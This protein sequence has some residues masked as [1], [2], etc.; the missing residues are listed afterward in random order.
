[1]FLEVYEAVEA[2]RDM[3]KA[4]WV[5]FKSVKSSE[6]DRWP[7]QHF[8]KSRAAFT[9]TRSIVCKPLWHINETLSQCGADD[10]EW[11]LQLLNQSTSYLLYFSN[12]SVGTQTRTLVEDNGKI[13]KTSIYCLLYNKSIY[14]GWWL[15]KWLTHPLWM[16]Y[17]NDNNN[18]NKKN[19]FC[20]SRFI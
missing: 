4:R 15:M 18:S 1:M 10:A 19:A 7:V 13:F 6:N 16:V 2:C 9:F 11:Q 17:N 5:M 12:N 3:N 20:L 8:N 14:R